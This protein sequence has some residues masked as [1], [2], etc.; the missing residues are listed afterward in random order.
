M[1]NQMIP[2][3]LMDLS[4]EQQQL[5]AGGLDDE[6]YSFRKPIF[7]RRRYLIRGIF[8]VRKLG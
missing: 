7:G 6:G 1:S 4:T 5:L 2:D 8:S 3:L